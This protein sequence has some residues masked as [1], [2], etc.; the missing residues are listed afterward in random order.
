MSDVFISYAKED[1]A[2][3]ADLAAVLESKGWTVWWD[4]QIPPGRTFDE[5][6]EEA[7]TSAR[8]V[9]V[10]WSGS[11]VAS[12]WVRAEAST[13]DERGILVPALIEPISPPLEFRRIQAADLM[14]WRGDRDD[15]EL[16]HLLTT[17]GTLV[18]RNATE[19]PSHSAPTRRTRVAEKS[20]ALRFAAVA[21]AGVLAGAVLVY[22]LRPAATGDVPASPVADPGG[23][24]RQPGSAEIAPVPTP[25]ASDVATT[26]RVDLLSA[27]NG[28]HLVRA[29]H[30]NWNEPID[31]S[32][33]WGYITGDEAV[34]GF[35][36]NRPATFDTFRMLITETRNWNIKGFELLAG[37]D[38][39][40][41]Y[42]ESL[43]KFETEN[44]R[45]F[46]SPWQE[47]KFPPKR[48]T[49]LKVR[50]LSLHRPTGPTQV[51]QWQL[52]GSF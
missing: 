20:L 40:D 19:R 42:F 38:A 29:P 25:G 51:E 43:G 33:N 41:G 27:K 26:G 31:G 36:D 34:Y 39:P 23:E 14:N 30:E 12:R 37:G 16:Q 46:P 28:G 45:L 10:L 5:V 9:I 4:R 22:S 35:K 18:S 17:V 7:L 6:I 50:V 32:E 47:F 48:A 44:V 1:R 11:S 3:A 8:C 15:Q 21:I 52:L 2:R 13:A 49:Y 24:P